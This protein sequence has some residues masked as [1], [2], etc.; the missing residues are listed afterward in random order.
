MN[1]FD[2]DIQQESIAES[3]GAR[4]HI[5]PRRCCILCYTTGEGTIL[6]IHA[7]GLWVAMEIEAKFRV[8]DAALF[9]ALLGLTAIGP[10]DLRAQVAIEHQHNT[11]FD[12]G[13]GRLR[14][15]RY[16]LRVRTLASHRVATLK[17]PTRQADGVYE[18]DEW[19]VTIGEDDAPGTW[20]PSE[21]RDRVLALLDG[22]SVR[23][24][25]TIE[26]FRQH[27][28]ALRG[29]VLLAELSLDEGVIRAGAQ[30]ELFRE[31]EIELVGMGVRA[32]LDGLVGLLRARFEL[33][34]EVLSKLA[35]GLRLLDRQM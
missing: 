8:A 32:D 33:V 6:C 5:M 15:Q 31:L 16:G 13:D 19:E 35:R 34:P 25:L 30:E 27:M 4:N 18:R 14:A 12:T 20:P 22:A 24:L 1:V 23:P 26:T 10:F 3:D 11:Y 21:V 28:Y 29:Q 17:G 9:P 7:K 2:N